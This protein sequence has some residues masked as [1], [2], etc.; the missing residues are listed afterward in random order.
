MSD[1]T[2]AQRLE[3]FGMRDDSHLAPLVPTPPPG[4]RD[5][6]PAGNHR[7]HGAIVRNWRELRVTSQPLRLTP[8]GHVDA[9]RIC[10]RWWH[11]GGGGQWWPDK[12]NTGITIEAA[13]AVKFGA[14]VAAAVA[15]LLAGEAK[16]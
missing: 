16:P 13:N 15:A 1:P 11:R 10:I 5:E 14:A 2:T 7:L 8:R 3:F 9:A 6:G 4:P 12:R